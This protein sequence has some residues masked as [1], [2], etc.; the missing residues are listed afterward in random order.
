[1]KR[2]DTIPTSD[3]PEMP[4]WTGHYWYVMRC[5]ALQAKPSLTD[6]QIDDLV[7]FFQSLRITT[8]CPDCRKHYTDDWVT[9]PFTR[10][11]ATDAG[12]AMQWVEDLRQRIEERKDKDL[13]AK[14][15]TKI[16]TATATTAASASAPAPPP[17]APMRVSGPFFHQRSIM[18]S[19]APTSTQR[20]L[21]IKSALQQVNANR[22]AREAGVERG[23]GCGKKKK[24]KVS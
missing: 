6:S 4:E 14:K 16:A 8:P 24:T 17:R 19:P 3:S 5:A 13:A 20:V 23:C 11:H 12:R 2:F 1:M 15:H 22:M 9:L 21:A 10:H 18:P 7:G